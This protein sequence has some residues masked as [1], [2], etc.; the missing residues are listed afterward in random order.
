MEP[1]IVTYHSD[2]VRKLM[3][4]RIS[5][6]EV[7]LLQIYG[8]DLGAS[9]SHR[10]E[11]VTFPSR[12]RLEEDLASMN[13]AFSQDWEDLMTEYLQVNKEKL[14]ILNQY[15]QGQFERGMLR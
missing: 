10:H 11:K 15:R 2:P 12:E 1:S 4:K 7:I 6:T 14:N 8:R 9:F 3:Y 13:K 5:P